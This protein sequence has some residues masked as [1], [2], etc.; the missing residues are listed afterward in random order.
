MV[1]MSM[2]DSNRARRQKVAWPARIR[3]KGQAEW[4][5]GRVLNLSVTG[6]LL[7]IEH[8]YP[9]G[10][11]VEVE[12]DFLNRHDSQVVVAGNGY[13]VREHRPIPNSS[14]VH[15]EMGCSIARRRGSHASSEAHAKERDRIYR[16][17]LARLA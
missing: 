3:A 6:A 5:V 1:A 7:Q 8:R 4:H 12:I 14:A 10:E 13:V 17:S 11:L 16:A 9:L 15:F 2:Q